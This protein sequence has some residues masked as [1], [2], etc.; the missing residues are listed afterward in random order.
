MGLNCSHNAFDGAYSAFNRFRQEVAK[1][2]GC[3]YPPHD[4]KSLDGDMWYTADGMTE[5]TNP[6]LYELF[7]HSDCDG[8]IAPGMC[9][10]LAAELEPLL[11]RMSDEGG[12]HIARNGGYR[13]T[14]QNFID[15]LREAGEAGEPLDFH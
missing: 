6:G 11:D 7:K 3:K 1:A 5:E 2:A 10:I 8:D 12:G 4:D 9:L 15:G 14:L 13:Q